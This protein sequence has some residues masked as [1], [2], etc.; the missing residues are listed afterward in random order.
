MSSARST[1]RAAAKALLKRLGLLPLAQRV[2]DRFRPPSMFASYERR[3]AELSR[4]Y[5]HVL[6]QRL[7][8]QN[9]SQK[10]ALICS[11][12]FP[13]VEIELGLVKA[14]QLANYTPVVVI[15]YD[16]P[17]GNLLAD[18]Y[19]LAAVD[20]IHLWSEFMGEHDE[21][22]AETALA[23]YKTIWDL[24]DFEY[25]GVRVGR[26]AVSS[27]LRTTYKGSLDL[28]DPTDRQLLIAAVAHSMAASVAAQ[29]ILKQFKPHLAMFV[30]N[31]Y[32]PLGELFDACLQ[33]DVEAIQWQ[34][35]QKS[36]ALIFKRYDRNTWL[37]HPSYISADSW[38]A[39]CDMEWTEEHPKKLDRDLYSTYASGDWYSVVGTQFNKSLVDA[40]HLRER[41]GLDPKKKTVVIFP[42]ILWD[43]TL[44]WVKCIFRDFEEWLVETVRAACANDQVN[45]VIKIHPAN[46]RVRED[47]SLLVESAEVTALNKYIGKLPP[48]IIM[49]PPESEISTYSVFQIAD[50]CLTVCGTVGIE[51]ARLGIPVLTAG[52]GPYDSLGF[53]VDSNNREEY[54]EKLQHIQEIERIS[55]AQQ[56]LAQRFA[57]A[58]FMMRPWIAKSVTLRYLPNT[59]RFVYDGQ[60]NIDS[61]EDWYQAEDLRAFI[62]WVKDPNKPAE[63]LAQAPQTIASA[64]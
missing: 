11:P 36:N 35:A 63:F 43:A 6:G 59:K 4:K 34:Q 61:R 64:K 62:D 49:I 24:L 13:E 15:P 28:Q 14:L 1:S 25:L 22:A 10:V 8:D 29:R 37:Q 55:P 26:L 57:Y 32:S 16:G 31:I 33:Q 41:F 50:A 30:D 19:R 2:H 23:Q 52:R 27:V 51:A 58:H 3:F 12:G 17:Y 9:A 53:T 39:I 7:N 38:Q 54:L 20:T 47:G 44:F 21:A 46:R 45:W 5:A 48:H 18:H 42:H 40:A 56:E 60:I